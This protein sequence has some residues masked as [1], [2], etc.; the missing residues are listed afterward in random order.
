VLHPEE[1]GGSRETAHGVVRMLEECAQQFDIIDSRME[2]AP[3][4]V[5]VL[6][7]CVMVEA[8]LRDKLEGFLKGGGKLLASFESGMNK[9]KTE[10][11]LDAL[12]V[13]CV[14]PG[15]VAA[16]GK[17]ARGRKFPHCDFADY[18]L[19]HG[20]V[21]KGLSEVEHVM[22]TRGVEVAPAAG[23][24]VLAPTVQSYFDRS[25][26]H[27]CSHRQTPSS[28][29]EGPAGIVRD[30]NCIYFA[31]RIFELYGQYGALWYK[32]LVRNALDL[33]LPEP[34]L[35]HD[36][37]STLQ[38]TVTE[39]ATVNRWV[40]HLLHYIPMSRAT[41]LDIIEDVIPVHEVKVSVRAPRPVKRVIERPQVFYDFEFWENGGRV[42]FVVPRIVGH[43]MVE[44]EFER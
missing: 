17:P 14:G 36:G 4:K 38:A 40:V 13:R 44:L 41:E 34:V 26:R 5:L 28:G 42:E 11:A 15:P 16:D 10:F 9:E 6:P 20:E 22:Y 37:P 39:Q 43:E 1:F 18:I 30:G 29:K 3:Y 24:E 8:A 33:L 2:F 21:G 19:P 25:F 27:F 7:D 35:R 31:H 32:K 12:G 23:A